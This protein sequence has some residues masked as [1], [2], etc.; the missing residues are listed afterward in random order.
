MNK[1]E[2]FNHNLS[3]FFGVMTLQP[4]RVPGLKKKTVCKFHKFHPIHVTDI[5]DIWAILTVL[6]N[7]GL[8][9]ASDV[10]CS[11]PNPIALMRSAMWR[12]KLPRYVDNCISEHSI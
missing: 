5:F 2:T 10:G 8:G 9:G 3:T 4:T 1:V 12:H 6:A 7:V 11:T